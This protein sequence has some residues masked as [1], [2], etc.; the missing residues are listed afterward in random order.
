MAKKTTKSFW[1]IFKNFGT[2]SKIAIIIIAVILVAALV[3]LYFYKPDL[4]SAIFGNQTSNTQTD[5]NKNDDG[6]TDQDAGDKLLGS[7]ISEETVLT[8][9][10]GNLNVH[11]INVGQ[12]D[13]I[14]IE[15][16]DGKDMLIDGGR[17]FGTSTVT[18]VLDYLKLVDDDRN[19]TYLMVTH[20][21]YDHFSMLT[22]VIEYYD[23]D[24]FYLPYADVDDWKGST[25]PDK[26]KFADAPAKIDTSSYCSFL[27]A[28]VEEPDA[29]IFLNLNIFEIEGLS[30][31]ISFVFYAL[32]EEEYAELPKAER[33][34][35]SPVGIL[36]YKGYQIVFTG[37][38][39]EDATQNYLDDSPTVDCDL[40]KVA[41]H[42]SSTEG[43]NSAEFLNDVSCEYAV[44]SCGKDNSYNH[45]HTELMDRLNAMDTTV[46]LTYETGSI[47]VSIDASGPAA[48][49]FNNLALREAA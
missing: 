22:K 28:A 43:S 13:A 39:A 17:Q 49:S 30:D 47:V 27:K 18:D 23:V 32:S 44:I 42:G 9:I 4:F 12:G 8:S 31:D 33:N 41:H 11:F 6:N 45:P 36:E 14:Y 48:F 34:D 26:D 24:N 25:D 40:L 16:P 1:R 5:D 46:Y 7:L 19:L 15:F 20:P 37:D 35:M 29:N 21:D 3:A 38:A 2:R 10:D